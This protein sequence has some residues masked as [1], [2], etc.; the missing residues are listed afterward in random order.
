MSK[1]IARLV[2]LAVAVTLCGGVM[3]GW[4]PAATTR[5]SSPNPKRIFTKSMQVTTS[6]K[7]VHV[8]GTFQQVE[9]RR[10]KGPS[11]SSTL[12][13]HFHGRVSGHPSALALTIRAKLTKYSS[14]LVNTIET[15]KEMAQRTGNGKW[16][17]SKVTASTP[18]SLPDLNKFINLLRKPGAGSK[19][20]LL[21]V[22]KLNG[23]S[24]WR[25]HANLAGKLPSSLL[26]LSSPAPKQT[27]VTFAGVFFIN[28]H[29]YLLE[30]VVGTG[31]T[32]DKTAAETLSL[33]S[34]FSKYGQPVS[35]RLPAACGG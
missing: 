1:T 12:S 15:S 22:Q 7:T 3:V 18:T 28:Q 19:F 17:C 14:I 33:D 31:K 9:T 11:Y 29:N 25:I 24:V 23:A 8:G 32:K 35:I 20:A 27:R 6:M 30:R 16:H 26:G 10:G 13:G 34:T 5:T 4:G 21:G 2:C